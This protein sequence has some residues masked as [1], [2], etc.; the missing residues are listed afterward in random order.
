MK[1]FTSPKNPRLVGGVVTAGPKECVE[2]WEEIF[3]LPK[4]FRIKDVST[5]TWAY[6]RQLCSQADHVPV[7]VL[8]FEPELANR[9]SASYVVPLATNRKENSPVRLDPGGLDP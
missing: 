4:R 9:G 6:P 2:N 1:N 5:C 3:G 8:S 7:F